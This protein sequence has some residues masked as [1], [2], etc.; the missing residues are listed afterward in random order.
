MRIS[1][2]G[3]RNR[4]RWQRNVPYRFYNSHSVSHIFRPSFALGVW[5]LASAIGSLAQVDR[6]T[7]KHFAT[8]SEVI[9]SHGMAA[10]AQPL[11][12]EIAIDILKQGGSAV[13]AA[14]AA[15]AALGLMEPISC[16]VGGD[17]FAVIWDAKSQRLYGING[18]GRSPMGLSYEQLK[19][20]LERLGTKQIPKF[21]V[22]PINVPGT[23]DAWFELHQKFG[24]LPISQHLAPA[25]KYAEEG[26]PVSE[27][28]VYYWGRNVAI[29]AQQP[30]GIL[31]TY[32]VDGK[33][34]VKGE[35]FRNRDLAH[36]Y[37]LLAE[38]GRDVF[39]KGE[40]AEKIDAFFRANGGY[41]RK[42]DF[43]A[44][45]SEWVEPI[46]T[47]YRGYDVYELPPNTQ[48]VTT[49]EMLNILEGYDLKTMGFGSADTLHVMVE[50][51]KLA[52]EDRAR[53]YGDPRFSTAPL[54]T[55]LA[56][57]Y[58]T[59]RRNLIDRQHASRHFDAGTGKLAQ[60]D[61]TYF[62]VADKDGNMISIIQSNYRGMGSGIVVP[63]LGFGFQDRGEL[64]TMEAGHPNVY[65]PGKRP[66][67]TLIPGFVMKN[68]KPWLAFGVMG[69]DMQPQGHVQVLTNLIDF[70]MNLQEAGDAPRWH[71]EGS[72]E[73]T[74][75]VMTDGGY[76]EV[77]TGFPYDNIRELM[78]RG[79]HVR[80]DLGGYGGYQAIMRD[81]VTGVY[82]G[83]SESRKDGC[84]IG[85]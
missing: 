26:F 31:Q 76:V 45:Q 35:I 42:E 22:L 78:N 18:G 79:H 68:G 56:K 77:E 41:L 38:Q 65:A 62:C 71:H 67:H 58:A 4:D 29:L 34:P 1:N 52:F 54:E 2:C 74:G 21:G 33:P 6:I 32:T 19:S 12:S 5:L 20:E 82:Y 55:L 10:T 9:A 44:H 49:L 85:Y 51:K 23:V 40:I 57:E 39:Y 72:S 17:L 28:I 73:P 3:L 24:K 25:I 47:N 63:G 80:F 83:A 27:L 30:G 50:A 61:T 69:G 37:R 7:G 11:A 15:N 13:D 8:R 70:G 59:Q 60:G 84:A 14:I 46:S 66:F 64:F 75:E 81:P 16:G 36:T 53:S 48:G 43:A